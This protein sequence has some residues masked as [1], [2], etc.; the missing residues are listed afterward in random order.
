[1]LN[2]E[3]NS[4]LQSEE[5]DA[6]GFKL[7]NKNDDIIFNRFKNKLSVIQEESK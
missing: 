1:M 2:L 6:E 3:I 7:Q 4:S 5:E